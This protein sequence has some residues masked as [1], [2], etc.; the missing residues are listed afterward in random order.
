M[1]QKIPN[2]APP[3]IHSIDAV[4][5]CARAYS[6]LMAGLQGPTSHQPFTA[7]AHRAALGLAGKLRASGPQEVIYT[8]RLEPPRLL[9]HVVRHRGRTPAGH[10]APKLRNLTRDLPAPIPTSP[11]RKEA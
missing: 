11:P 2:G 3:S 4:Q 7:P 9:P 6:S 1:P 8:G 10:A 5:A